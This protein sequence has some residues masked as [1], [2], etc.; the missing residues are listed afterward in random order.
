MTAPPPPPQDYGPPA[1]APPP[2]FAPPAPAPPVTPR[3][4]SA[5]RPM[6]PPPVAAPPPPLDIVPG[7]TPPDTPTGAAGDAV[8]DAVGDAA[9]PRPLQQWLEELET[10]ARANAADARRDSWRFWALKIPAIASSGAATLLG[11]QGFHGATAGLAALAT[12]CVLVD[13]VN[14][15]GALRNAHLR[16]VHDLRALENEV[17]AEWRLGVLRGGSAGALAAD[18]LE[19]SQLRWRQIAADLRTAETALDAKTR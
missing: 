14:P 13:G 9:M 7:W 4:A 3:P 2:P 18:I 16:A 5:P 19:R 17:L 6:A 8:R 11:T 15:G 1:Q 10:W 12:V